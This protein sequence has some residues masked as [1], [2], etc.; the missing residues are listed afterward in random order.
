[1]FH[2]F[3]DVECRRELS[4]VGERLGGDVFKGYGSKVAERSHHRGAVTLDDCVDDF[5]LDQVVINQVST[6]SPIQERDYLLKLVLIMLKN[7]DYNWSIS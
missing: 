7:I 1:M 6:A 4:M 2:V 5:V 3:Y